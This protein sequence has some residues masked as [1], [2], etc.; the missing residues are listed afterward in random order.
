MLTDINIATNPIED[1]MLSLDFL[2]ETSTDIE[3]MIADM[4]QE[5]IKTLPS[6]TK[7]QQPMLMSCETFEMFYSK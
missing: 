7:I 3:K 6:K 2:A 5:E 4:L 1:I